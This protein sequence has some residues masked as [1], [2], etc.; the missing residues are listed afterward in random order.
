MF[1]QKL[2]AFCCFD[3]PLLGFSFQRIIAGISPRHLAGGSDGET[4]LPVCC[5][6]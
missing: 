3:Y 4:A 6:W 2:L 5:F 1:S